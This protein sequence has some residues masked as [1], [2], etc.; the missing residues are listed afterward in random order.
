MIDAAAHLSLESDLR[1]AI[2]YGGAQSERT[3]K[4]L[5]VDLSGTLTAPC[6]VIC[7]E[8]CPM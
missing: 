8:Y 2:E 5:T 6:A 4:A 3:R 7:T 1:W